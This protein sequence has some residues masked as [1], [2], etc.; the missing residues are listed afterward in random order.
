LLINSLIRLFE[1]YLSVFF[2]RRDE[3][4]ALQDNTSINTKTR[5][6]VKKNKKQHP[7]LNS[8]ML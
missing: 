1:I 4:I 5:K 6:V 2:K 8:N 7:I 3:K